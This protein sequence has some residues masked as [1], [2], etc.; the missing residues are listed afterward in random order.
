[1]TLRD[2]YVLTLERENEMLQER[3]FN[4][5][6][7]LGMKIDTPLALDLTSH[8]SAL[9]GL[10]LKRDLVTKELAMT[11]FYGMGAD[12]EEPEQKIIDVWICKLRAKLKSY[13]VAI[14]TKWGQGWWMTAQAKATIQQMMKVA[15]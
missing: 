10:L 11:A 5:E 9:L 8:E 12:G 2:E 4:L 6:S 15:A 13:G 14:E 1:M 7:A 3:I